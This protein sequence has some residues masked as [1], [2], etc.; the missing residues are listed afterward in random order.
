MML[1]DIA[2]AAIVSA[3]VAIAIASGL[4]SITVV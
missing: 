3:T 2:A 1:A 4:V